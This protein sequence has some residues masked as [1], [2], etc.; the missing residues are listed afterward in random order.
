MLVGHASPDT[1]LLSRLEPVPPF[2]ELRTAAKAA[3]I[4]LNDFT[5][6]T[7]TADLSPGDS[8]TALITLH[9]KG[10]RLTQWLVY[11]QVVPDTN[12][13]K[14]KKPLVLYTTTG[15][16]F[17]FP[18]SASAFH[19]R[20][21]GPYVDTAS[22]WGDP[23]P[24]DK[25]ASASVTK[26][27]LG[28][29]LD[30]G[31]AA[32]C[33]WTAAGKETGATNFSF[34]FYGS[35]PPTNREATARKEAAILHVTREEERAVVSSFPTLTSYFGAVSQTPNLESIMWKIVSLPSAWSIVRH[36]GVHGSIDLRFEDVHP[37]SPPA[38]WNIQSHSPVYVLPLSIKLN[39][40]NALK[41][42]L[43]VTSSRPPLLTCGGIVG[44]L[45]EDPANSKNYIILRIISAHSGMIKT[46]SPAK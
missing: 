25:S 41:V 6:T 11:F 38:A 35:P 3:S 37:V 46:N 16:K 17:E 9:Q 15:N 8:A 4:P 23:A 2:P 29:G 12:V 24:E 10:N 36:V 30:K 45:A 1:H 32:V 33:R 7:N 44:F 22:F 5:A 21:I 20:E 13:S 26:D 34:S 14:P 18:R 39:G 19:I 27:F 40:Y 43:L 28:L 42:S 31:A